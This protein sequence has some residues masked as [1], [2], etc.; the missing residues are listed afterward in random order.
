MGNLT[1][2]MNR[3]RGEV[4]ALRG[5]RGALVQDLARGSRDLSSTVSAMRAD[6]AAAHAAM[7]KQTRGEREAFVVAG[8]N[9]V[10]SLIGAFSRDRADMALKGT[11]Y[12]KVFL[13]EMGI[14]VL[15]MCK[16]T[17]DDL[18][19]ARLVWRVRNP[20]KFRF[21]PMK[22]EPVIVKSISHTVEAAVKKTAAAPEVKVEKPSVVTVPEFKE[23]KPPVT[24]RKPEK[25]EE[26]VKTIVMPKESVAK[27]PKVKTQ[28]PAFA[29]VEIPNPKEKSWQYG[30]PTKTLIKRKRDKK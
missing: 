5:A 16:N 11:H 14:Q 6:F 7:A 8:I 23:S 25:E 27:T 22:K 29:S 10:N 24:F 3:L 12:R 19:G 30:K 15:C 4:D 18:M 26:K 9:E 2:D 21:V 20:E 28:V 13:S 17:A 1:N